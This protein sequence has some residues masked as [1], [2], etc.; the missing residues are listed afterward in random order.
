MIELVVDDFTFEFPDGWRAI[1][2]DE[3]PFYRK[4]FGEPEDVKA[5]DVLALNDELFIIEA[6]NFR[7]HRIENKE[8]VKN[9]TLALE[10]AKKIR[11]TL[12][13]LYGAHRHQNE[14]L[15][16]FSGH[17]FGHAVPPITIAFLLEEDR[18]PTSHKSF[19]GIRPA[20]RTAIENKL[21]FLNVRFNLHN[22]HDMSTRYDWTVRW[23]TREEG[24]TENTAPTTPET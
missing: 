14:E 9:D 23:R 8:R 5:V 12:A 4:R 16:A 19:K 7:G 18:P 11:D 15:A 3:S 17:L 13:V 1:K 22:L 10:I 6:K 21:R 2:Y 24:P 20:L